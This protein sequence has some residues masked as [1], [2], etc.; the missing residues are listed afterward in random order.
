MKKFI[1]DVKKLL[2]DNNEIS[3]KRVIAITSFIVL[4]VLAFLSAYGNTTAG[5]FVWV[6]ASLTGC[7]SVLAL[8]EKFKK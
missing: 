1:E 3:H 2:S 8:I 7:E 4:V 5:E 6:F